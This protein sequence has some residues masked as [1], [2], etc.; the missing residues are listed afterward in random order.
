MH[1]T[2]APVAVVLLLAL[3]SPASA[4][5]EVHELQAPTPTQTG[6]FGFS[7]DARPGLIVVGAYNQSF[8]A[9]RSG[10]VYPCVPAG[11]AW[12]ASQELRA[13]D[14]FDLA[15]F[16]KSVALDGSR[17][18]VGSPGIPA[19]PGTLGGAVYV[20][21]SSSGTWLEEQKLVSPN[22]TL[23][24]GFG[25]A[26]A[27]DGD[28][29]VISAPG[30]N[31]FHGRVYV[32]ERGPGGWTLAAELSASDGQNGDRFG[33]AFALSGS[34]LVVGAINYDASFVIE[35]G[36]AYVF[37]RSTAGTWE[38]VDLLVPIIPQPSAHLGSAVA[39]EGDRLVI[40]APSG[41][42]MALASGT[43]YY[44]E[45]QAGVWTE[46]QKL[47]V[48]WARSGDLFGSALAL[49][50]SRLAVG[51][52]GDDFL[53]PDSGSVQT[54]E[55][56]AG[57]WIVLQRFGA[58]STDPSGRIGASVALLGSQLAA[59]GYWYPG[60]PLSPGAVFVFDQDGSVQRHCTSTPNSGGSTGR[61]SNAGSTSVSAN[62]FRLICEGVPPN[63]LG[64]F[65]YGSV[66]LQV[67]FGNGFLCVGGGS[68]GLVRLEALQANSLGDSVQL[69]DFTQ[70]PA[71]GTGSG[72]ILPGDTRSFQ[73]WF[74]DPGIGASFN[75][76]DA[77][78][79]T[80][81]P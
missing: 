21:E 76:S 18:L 20:F 63:K 52:S 46:L 5:C 54:F 4:Q 44:F 73:H 41:A 58:T 62:D 33:T 3:P 10:A 38:E 8:G 1:L 45:R 17:M 29:S 24:G 56:V 6:L 48:P 26:V 13:S 37:E 79:V 39:L 12:A 36:G 61:I 69:L 11:G 47:T 30:E 65:L 55:L 23:S 49:E 59:G 67:P 16:G 19:P 71:G 22:A 51:T 2:A 31:G 40:G 27:L 60:P 81:C 25:T 7:V 14:P 15:E 64:L 32:F 50:G 77:I 9:V 43:A 66:P 70:P 74:R 80:F 53:A 57:A 68:T 35:S 75:L 28:R 72:V 42:G 34:T 78:R